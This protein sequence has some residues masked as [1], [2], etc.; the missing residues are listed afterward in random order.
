MTL[1]AMPGPVAHRL[2]PSLLLVLLLPLHV[3]PAHP[4]D[5][6]DDRIDPAC[7]PY[8]EHDPRDYNWPYSH[9]QYSEVIPDV[10]GSFVAMTTLNLT[11]TEDAVVEYGKPLAPSV[12]TRAPAVAF[13]LEPDRSSTT[14]HTLLMVDP[15]MPFRDSPSQGEWVHWLIVNIPGNDTSQGNTLVEYAPPV[16]R[17]CP[18]NDRLCLKE[19]RI[20]FILWEQPHGPLSLQPEDVRIAAVTTTGRARYKARD[21]AVR[22]RLGLQIAM[23]FF[24]TYHEAGDSA[25]DA[26]PWW[27]VRDTESLARVRHLVPHVEHGRGESSSESKDEL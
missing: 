17:P 7:C 5:P 13:D 1:H 27:Y 9:Y 11:Y 10:L 24:E 4:D 12:V 18:A 8:P 6:W 20:T 23:N 22:H 15:D 19:H 25:F 2:L 3:E 21:F 14:L 26:Q 16:P